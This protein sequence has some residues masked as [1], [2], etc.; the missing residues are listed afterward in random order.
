MRQSQ[1]TETQLVSILK[2]ADAGRA[3]HAIGRT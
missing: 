1:F 2:E 3:V